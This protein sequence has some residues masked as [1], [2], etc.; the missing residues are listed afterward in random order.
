MILKAQGVGK[1]FQQAGTPIDVIRGLDLEVKQG[2][3]LAIIG[4]SGSGKSTLLSLISGLDSPTE[5]K[6]ELDGRDLSTFSEEELGQFRAKNVGIVFQQF[7]LMPHLDALENVS[8]PLEVARDP[9]ATRKATVALESVGLAHRLK[10]FPHQLSG[11]EKQRVAI[12]RALVIEPKLLLADEPSGSLDT[13]TGKQVMD[14]LFKLVDERKMTLVLVTHN[15]ELVRHCKRSLVL[16][17]GRLVE[18]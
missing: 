3:T 17:E 14:L 9:E 1:R 13:R 11:G 5:G 18:G 7:H 6:I 8:L 15:E 4:Q 16:A 12:A 10:H 2:E